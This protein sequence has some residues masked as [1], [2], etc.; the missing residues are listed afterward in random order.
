MRQ[1]KD[2]IIVVQEELI[3]KLKEENRRL[4]SEL[5]KGDTKMYDDDIINIIENITKAT[6]P[7][8]IGTTIAILIAYYLIQIAP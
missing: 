3:K 7:I 2:K 8:M 6:I 1:V 5:R 4:K